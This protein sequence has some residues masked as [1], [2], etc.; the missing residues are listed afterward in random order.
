MN[1]E[2]VKN[3]VRIFFEGMDWLFQ[4]QNLSKKIDW[5]KED[6]DGKAAEVIYREDYQTITIKIYPCFFEEE[7]EEQRK[8]LLHELCHVITIPMNRLT[9]EFMQGKAVT[10]ET[11][12]SIHER[13]TSQI[14]NILD[15]LLQKRLQ[16]AVRT[17]GEYLSKKK[18]GKKKK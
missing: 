2:Q 5:M 13:C 6:E 3:R 11:V 17:Y 18:K 9:I 1:R 16:Y 10:D 7:P 4:I 15:G 8:V 12:R 14:E